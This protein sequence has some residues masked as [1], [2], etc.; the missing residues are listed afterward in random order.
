MNRR[1]QSFDRISVAVAAIALTIF[2]TSFVIPVGYPI[3]ARA[4][5]LRSTTPSLSIADNRSIAGLANHLRK[6][7]AKMY[8]AYWCPHCSQQKELFGAAFRSIDYVEC[9]PGGANARPALCKDA[10]I[11]GYPTWEIKGKLYP[12]T[13]S[14]ED[15]AKLSG[16]SGPSNF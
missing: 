4:E 14:L 2:G 11:T 12:G 16:Y 13:Q 10:K 7:G 9:D 1:F 15:L 6:I 8:G 3:I 5:T